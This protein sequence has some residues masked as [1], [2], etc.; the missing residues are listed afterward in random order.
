MT[1][2]EPAIR[3]YLTKL[4]E[5]SFI[6]IKPGYNDTGASPNETKPVFSAYTPPAPK[7][8]AKVE[9]T[10]F[11]ET[12]HTF[13]QKSPQPVAD[14]APAPAPAAATTAPKP[15][16]QDTPAPQAAP[17]SQTA[18]T[19]K[20]ADKSLLEKLHLKKVRSA[21]PASQRKARQ[22]R[23]NSLRSGPA[24]DTTCR[25]RYGCRGCRCRSSCRNRRSH[26]RAGE[27]A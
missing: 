16:A 13:R 18:T 10:R 8:K 11:R 12:T 25:P 22:A 24:Q 23:E 14:T 7:K 1:R 19:A 15:A 26:S 17:A 2:M 4:R 5:E 9:R 3:Q 27:S 21:Q 20:P 6:D